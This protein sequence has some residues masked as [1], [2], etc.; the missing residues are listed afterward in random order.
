MII[1]ECSNRALA[2]M[3]LNADLLALLVINEIDCGLST[4]F[5]GNG[6]LPPASN[7]LRTPH[8]RHFRRNNECR[9]ITPVTRPFFGN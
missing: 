4:T 9:L 6:A 5:V 8:C 1:S 3:Q 2:D 7:V